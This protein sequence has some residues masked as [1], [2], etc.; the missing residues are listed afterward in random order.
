M[1]VFIWRTDKLRL[2][3]G[4]ATAAGVGAILTSSVIT[5]PNATAA[6]RVT[7][8]AGKPAGGIGAP[9]PKRPERKT[10]PGVPLA[11]PSQTSPEQSAAEAAA[12]AKAKATGKPV[13][14][15][16]LATEASDVVA[17]PSGSFSLTQHAEPVRVKHGAAWTPVD[18]TLRQDP[19][20]TVSPA[21]SAAGLT[22]SGGGSGPLA[23]MSEDADSVTLT[24]PTPLPTPT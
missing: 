1:R 19:D 10:T 6:T 2:R 14:V 24:W 4:I 17:N 12:Q 22:F 20:G 8:V 21:A 15:E 16:A 23:R 18:L 13:V 11:T 9:A 3:A 7:P 5:M